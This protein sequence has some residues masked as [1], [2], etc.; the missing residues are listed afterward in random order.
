MIEGDL[1]T[2][3]EVSARQARIA[4]NVPETMIMIVEMHV[5]GKPMLRKALADRECVRPRMIRDA[6]IDR[7][8]WERGIELLFHNPQECC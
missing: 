1:L 6:D 7:W 5:D 3:I 4:H 2:Q 8:L